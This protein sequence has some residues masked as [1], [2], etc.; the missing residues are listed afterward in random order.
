MAITDY[1]TL[2][3][4]LADY[5]HRSDFSDAVLS[6][7]VS[8][9]EIRLNRTL[10]VL[11]MEAETELSLTAGVNEIDLPAR[12]S[13]QINLQYKATKEVLES[14]DNTTLSDYKNYDDVPAKPYFFTTTG[15]KIKFESYSDATYA[16]D[17]KY[18]KK[19]DIAADDTNWLLENAPDAYLY[20]SLMEAKAYAK[21][22][23]DLATWSEGLR[24][25]IKD[26]NDQASRTRRN[27]K[28]RFDT[29]KTK[30][31]FNINRGY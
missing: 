30:G 20:G 9:A 1:A 19:F 7:F 23:E 21:S 16:L 12:F 5:L 2:K 17:F 4:T 3:T 31:S 26:L 18:F 11:A 15:E 22:R 6:N 29:P 14:V 28:A 13:E 25:S 8:F 10:R 27:S 24:L